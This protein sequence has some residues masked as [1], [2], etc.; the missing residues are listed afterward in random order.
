MNVIISRYRYKLQNIRKQ[1][2]PCIILC[3]VV[4]PFFFYIHQLVENFVVIVKLDKH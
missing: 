2:D 3:H 1:L 4:L